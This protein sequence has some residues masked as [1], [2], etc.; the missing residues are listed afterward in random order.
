MSPVNFECA[1]KHF[2]HHLTDPLYNK[3]LKVELM[4]TENGHLDTDFVKMILKLQ[5]SANFMLI[6]SIIYAKLRLI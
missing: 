1:S 5:F 6:L 4:L 3:I 2:I